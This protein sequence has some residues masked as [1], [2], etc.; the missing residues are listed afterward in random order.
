LQLRKMTVAVDTV[1]L[2][3][4]SMKPVNSIYLCINAIAVIEVV[5]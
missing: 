3:K 2:W 1:C 5:S 4:I